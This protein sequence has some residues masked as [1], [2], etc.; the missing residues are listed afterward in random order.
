MTDRRE[1]V[2]CCYGCRLV[3]R[4]VGRQGEGGQEGRHAW[5]ILR[6]AAGAFLAMNV[7]TVS[8]LLYTGR[9]KTRP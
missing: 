8:L 3:S 1:P 7:M 6:L 9:S 2:F 5:N 4:I